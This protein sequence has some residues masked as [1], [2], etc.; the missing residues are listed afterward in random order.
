MPSIV[1]S[2]LKHPRVEEELDN[3]PS[4]SEPNHWQF[5]FSLLARGILR[6]ATPTSFSLVKNSR[7]YVTRCRLGETRCPNRQRPPPPTMSPWRHKSP[8]SNRK[9]PCG[10]RFRPRSP[11]RL[12]SDP[13][14]KVYRL[15][16][17]EGFS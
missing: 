3:S 2:P 8:A 12:L 5:A 1:S 14:P 16:F 13:P 10:S 6:A 11:T 7:S 15:G 9:R 4:H 17:W